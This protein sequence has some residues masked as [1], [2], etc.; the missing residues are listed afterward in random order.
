MT[1]SEA[2]S[3]EHSTRF[4]A[5]SRERSCP[6]RSS[7][8]DQDHFACPVRVCVPSGALVGAWGPFV[9][10]FQSSEELAWLLVR[11]PWLRVSLLPDCAFAVASAAGLRGA[12]SL[13]PV[14]GACPDTRPSIWP[15]SVG[16]FRALSRHRQSCPEPVWVGVGGVINAHFCSGLIWHC[17]AEQSLH[18]PPRLKKGPEG[19]NQ[20]QTTTRT[21]QSKP[22][23]WF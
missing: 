10:R 14:W 16:N 2:R 13:K 9:T 11:G 15:S 4:E 8:G 3:R 20:R 12:F 5:R 21:P 22:A 17:P 18:I 19:D 7:C 1:R 6:P 23:A